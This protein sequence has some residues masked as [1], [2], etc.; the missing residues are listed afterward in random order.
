MISVN[1]VVLA[2][3]LSDV[4]ETRELPDGTSEVW[5]RLHVP[6]NGKRLLP[7]PCRAPTK[8]W[9]V[10]VDDPDVVE[11]Q[12]GTPLLVRGKLVRR[13]FRDAGGGRSV[14]EVEATEVK[15]LEEV[16]V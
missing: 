4:P 15:R 16:E 5:F 12:R 8:A 9:T 2:G 14:T 1:V 7:L 6:E 3:R 11:A 10:G 13:F